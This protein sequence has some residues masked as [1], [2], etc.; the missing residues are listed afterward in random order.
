MSGDKIS[1]IKSSFVKSKQSGST[2]GYTANRKCDLEV[3]GMK[4]TKPSAKLM[5]VFAMVAEREA[6]LRRCADQRSHH[7]QKRKKRKITKNQG[8]VCMRV[9]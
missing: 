3:A 1:R 6:I 7:V 9:S 2:K 5:M 4:I 8:L